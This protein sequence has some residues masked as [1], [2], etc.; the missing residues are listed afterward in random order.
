MR[1]LDQGLTELYGALTQYSL[2][3][4]G[5]H[6]PQDGTESG[7]TGD[8]TDHSLLEVEVPAGGTIDLAAIDDW[9]L[10]EAQAEILDRIVGAAAGPPDDAE[11][12]R[13]RFSEYR[14]SLPE[15]LAPAGLEPIDEP[16]ASLLAAQLAATGGRPNFAG[17][18]SLARL[19][20]GEACEQVAVLELGSG[21]VHFPEPL[22]RL[23]PAPQCRPERS[24]D[25]REDSRLL[26]YTHQDGDTVVTDY[27]LWEGERR[28]FRA[29]AQYRRS[30]ERFCSDSAS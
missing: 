10:H 25:F 28:A 3:R 9:F 29:I 8:C 17:S 5:T 19:P 30:V 20:C 6:E 24:L 13:P 14:V 7:S 11:L 1:P 15:T 2:C 18:F 12:G 27:L 4:S 26:E 23:A 22:G 16:A 21:T